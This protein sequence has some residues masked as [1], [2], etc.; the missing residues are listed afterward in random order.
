MTDSEGAARLSAPAYFASIF[1]MTAAGFG[2]AMLARPVFGHEVLQRLGLEQPPRARPGSFYAQRVQPLFDTHCVACHGPQR[3]KGQLRL[4]SYAAVL[5]GGRGGMTI[6]PRNA[7]ASEL[8][9]RI[10]LP[11]S[12]DRAMPPSGKTPL[13]PDEITV[14]R[15]WIEGGARGDQ[16]ASEVKG[17]PRL[18]KPA[19]IPRA[20]PA[21]VARQ[22]APLAQTVR[23]LQARLPGLLEYESRSSA[24]LTV[25]ASLGGK[26]FGDR[27]MNMLAAIA[28][29]VTRADFSGT[30]ISDASAPALGR[31]TTLESLRLAD[32]GITDTTLAALASLKNLRAL[33]VTGAS[34]TP[35]GLLPLRR[36]GVVLHGAPDAP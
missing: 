26:R 28:L 6:A 20:D 15:L 34:V 27:D 24:N 14:I 18:V 1:L 29:R 25:N 36:K 21:L 13:S 3:Q 23:Q 31:M 10:T 30:A 33:T 9:T 17:A 8:F 19:V 22:R 12:D 4:D 32:T 5:L 16:P 11:S 35:E 2:A 7:K